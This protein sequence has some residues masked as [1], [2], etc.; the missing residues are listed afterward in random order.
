MI[1]A[2]GV[3]VALL[4]QSVG[5][6]LLLF[7]GLAMLQTVGRPVIRW[8]LPLLFLLAAGGGAIY[9]T[10]KLPVRAIAENNA[11]AR[12]LVNIV[13]STGRGSFSWRIATDQRALTQIREH[14]VLGA[15]RWDW[16]RKIGQRPWGLA[17]LIFGQFGLVGLALA[18]GALLLPVLR[19]LHSQWN[20]P[21]W[22]RDA[23][24]PL[25][26]IVL[27]AVGDALLNS[28]FFYP[29]IMAAGAL[30]RPV[31]RSEAE[32]PPA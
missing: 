8:T 9:L 15:A 26:V 22:G 29:A 16:W 25:A 1:A 2:L 5:A 13:K 21:A 20:S 23:I 11:V 18:S 17:L 4:S 27:M 3:V 28:F 7:A 19:A 12:Q 14:P 30:G 6:I 24:A 32:R 31:E 10:G